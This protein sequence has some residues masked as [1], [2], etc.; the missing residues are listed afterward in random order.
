MKVAIVGRRNTGKSTFINTLSQTERMI[1]SEIPGTTRDSV[2]VRFELDG[3]SFIAIDTPG[4][5][6]RMH[7]TKSSVDFFSNHRAQRSIR[8]A[9]VV[10]LFLDP[11]EKI[12]RI[13]KQLVDY[14]NSQ[15]KPCLFVVNKWDL[16]AGSTPTSD[17]TEY[18]QDNFPAMWH[19]PIA[20]ITG[21]TGKNVKTLLNHAQMLHKQARSRVSTADLN[22]LVRA[23]VEHNPPPL[24][25]HHRPKIYYAT[26]VGVEPPTVVMFCNEPQWFSSPYRRYLLGVMRDKLEVPIKLHLRKRESNPDPSSAAPEELGAEEQAPS[27][28]ASAR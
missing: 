16:C 1:V 27:D 11:L 25:N 24:A 26:Q 18:L 14:I 20:Y 3:K 13:D 9:D 15:Y 7:T 21:Q 28:E 8:R 6:R 17:W 12:S 19:A 4:L 23:A 5:K 2:D 10:L 22:R